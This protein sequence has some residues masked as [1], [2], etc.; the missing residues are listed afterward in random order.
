MPPTRQKRVCKI[1]LE[2]ENISVSS[3]A[4]KTGS[5]VGCLAGKQVRKQEIAS[6]P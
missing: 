2:K 4:D 1:I 5:P 3:A 6:W